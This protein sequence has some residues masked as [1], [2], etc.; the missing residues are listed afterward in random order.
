MAEGLLGPRGS[1]SVRKIGAKRAPLAWRLQNALRWSFIK[2]WIA[3]YIIAPFANAWGVT[4][5]MSTD[6]NDT[7][8]LRQKLT[9]P[10]FVT[11]FTLVQNMKV[12]S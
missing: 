5:M 1:L 3:T 2:G 7:K 12:R 8:P 10:A 9:N 4:T 11:R 6:A